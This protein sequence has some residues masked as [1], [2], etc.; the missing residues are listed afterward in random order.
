[1]KNLQV[2]QYIY[3]IN[4]DKGLEVRYMFLMPKGD[5][6]EK[7]SE[8]VAATI[9]ESLYLEI[10]RLC[11]LMDRSESYICYRLIERGLASYK[12]DGRILE[13][14]P[15]HTES[16]PVVDGGRATE[17]AKESVHTASSRGRSGS[18]RKAR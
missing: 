8:T 9:P 7:R 11:R 6:K 3:F 2:C 13:E 17:R 16:V 10:D 1:M 12:R 18:S 15:L 14:V 4:V 5:A